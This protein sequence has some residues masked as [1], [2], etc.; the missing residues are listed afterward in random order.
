MDTAVGG[1][2]GG[3]IT[4]ETKDFFGNFIFSLCFVCL[5]WL[6]KSSTAVADPEGVQG[7]RFN[8]PLCPPFLNILSETKLFHF[9]GIFKKNKIKSV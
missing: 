2:A 5:F 1:G 3:S 6:T 4:L 7:V 9:H 8:F